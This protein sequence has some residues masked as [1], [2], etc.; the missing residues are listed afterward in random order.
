MNIAWI[1][2][3]YYITCPKHFVAWGIS[4]FYYLGGVFLWTVL[5][6]LGWDWI[7]S[8]SGVICVCMWWEDASCQGCMRN[9]STFMALL[10]VSSSPGPHSPR[11]SCVCVGTSAVYTCTHA[12]VGTQR[13]CLPVVP[14]LHFDYRKEYTHVLLLGGFGDPALAGHALKD[15]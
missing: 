3:L 2:M 14:V 9:L 13:S 4:R 8:K 11:N 12:C 6:H 5:V 15:R 10:G 7:I 1:S